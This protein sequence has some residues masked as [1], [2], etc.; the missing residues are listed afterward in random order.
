MKCFFVHNRYRSK[1]NVSGFETAQFWTVMDRAEYFDDWGLG[2][3]RS[4]AVLHLYA[5]R[6]G[7]GYRHYVHCA[8]AAPALF[9]FGSGGV[10]GSLEPQIYDGDREPDPGAYPGASFSGALARCDMD[11]LSVRFRRFA[12]FT[13]L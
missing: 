4:P 13:V 1:N 7:A 6:L 2:T 5:H 8:N 9:W 12:G 3:L 11:Y 10:R